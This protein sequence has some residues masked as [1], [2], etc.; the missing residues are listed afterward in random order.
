M[1]AS[2]TYHQLLDVDPDNGVALNN[3]ACLYAGKLNDLEQAQALAQRARNALPGDPAIMDTLGWILHRQ[4]RYG[5]AASLLRDAA[6]LLPRSA[7]VQCH[8]GMND[9]K[10][11]QEAEAQVAFARA[12]ELSKTFDGHEGMEECL[13]VL[14]IDPSTAG[15]QARQTLEKRL[16]N[17]ANDPVALMRLGAIQDRDGDSA[18][19]IRTYEVAIKLVPNSL[20]AHLNLARIHLD[21][22]Q[23]PRKALDYARTAR[24][25]APE[26]PQVSYTVGKLAYRAGDH[27]WAA[28]LLRECSS[29]M[30][31]D[32]MLF[33]DLGLAEISIGEAARAT[34]AF[35][36]ALD[37]NSD[38]AGAADTRELLAL[39]G[40]ILDPSGLEKSAEWVSKLISENPDHFP[41]T[42]V[43]GLIHEQRGDLDAAKQSHQGILQPDRFPSFAPARKRLA[44][45]AIKE[46]DPSTDPALKLAQ[47]ARQDFP[48]D[49]EVAA[50]LGRVAFH[51]QDFETV[52]RVLSDRAIASGLD[53]QSYYYLGM[54]RFQMKQ[55]NDCRAALQRALDLGLE[56]SLAAKAKQTLSSL[57]N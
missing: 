10:L 54:A 22:L 29:R 52:V 15:P 31:A 24:G 2:K 51:H 40:L 17:N 30:P 57:D 49:K 3:L 23:D 38:F 26:D 8:L 5:S 41:A 13:L 53:A 27:Q 43:A 6:R 56:Q 46:L 32:P 45:V 4:G 44:L 1:D 50:V 16:E 7:E 34:N 9:Y 14:A 18:T 47:H 11:G 37:L 28:S 42:Y 48:Q 12:G 33:H 19:A 25:L 39:C 35:Q 55:K 20:P 36:R 21:G